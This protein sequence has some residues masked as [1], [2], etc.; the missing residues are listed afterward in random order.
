MI[1]IR[2]QLRIASFAGVNRE[3]LARR[4]VCG[5]QAGT[6]VPRR[7]GCVGSKDPDLRERL[8]GI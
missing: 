6:D 7:M 4:G 3:N 1:F 8:D 2:G 5:K